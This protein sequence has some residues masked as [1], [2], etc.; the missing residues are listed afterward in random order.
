MTTILD[1]IKQNV[2]NTIISTGETF[3][4]LTEM[5]HVMTDIL[6]DAQPKIQ[7]SINNVNLTTKNLAD[8]SFEIKNTIEKGYVDKTL[9]NF[10]ES[11]A[12][13]VLTTKNINGFSGNL[14]QEGKRLTN[15]LLYNLNITVKNA[16]E[17]IVGIGNTL[18]KKLGG[19]RLVFSG[20]DSCFQK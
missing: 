14:N 1:E 8:S 10:Q 12:N 15:C 13:F 19:L 5:I 3:N 16:N 7:D 18:K 6:K 9:Y 20:I 2:N 4:A 11:S 17:I